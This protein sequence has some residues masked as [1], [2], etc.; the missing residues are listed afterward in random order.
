MRCNTEHNLRFGRALGR[1]KIASPSSVRCE[2]AL[3]VSTWLSESLTVM[4]P[5]GLSSVPDTG[6]RPKRGD[7]TTRSTS[8]NACPL[9]L[10]DLQQA[11]RRMPSRPSVPPDRNRPGSYYAGR[12]HNLGRQYHREQ[13][14]PAAGPRV[15]NTFGFPAPQIASQEAA[16]ER[17]HDCAC[18][19]A[20]QNTESGDLR[21]IKRRS[22]CLCGG[23]QFVHRREFACSIH[24]PMNSFLVRPLGFGGH[25]VSSY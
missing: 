8:P 24:Q 7:E 18:T 4:L 17:R 1:T 19:P 25:I 2:A 10:R 15:T 23:N 16:D 6:R 13:Q 3:S 22:A 11:N 14:E 12:L 21:P 9:G 20:Q 5:F